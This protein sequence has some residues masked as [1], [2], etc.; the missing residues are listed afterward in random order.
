M[1]HAIAG[2]KAVLVGPLPPPSGG[3]ANQTQQLAR[4]LSTEGIDVEL[5]Q[6]NAPYSPSWVAKYKIIRAFFRFLPYLRSLWRSTKRAQFV[7][8]MAN[9]GWAWHLFAAPAV[10]IAR[11]HRKPVLINYRGG[12]AEAF[13]KRS[14]LFIKPTLKIADAIVVPSGFLEKIFA[15]RGF[16]TVIIANIIDLQRFIASSKAINVSS[17]H[18]IVTRNLEPI[19]D[20]PTSLRA[21][22]IVKQNYPNAR[23]SIA[24]SGPLL[25]ELKNFA[26]ELGIEK[27]VSFVGRL[28]NENIASL[29]HSAD[30]FLN[31]SLTDNMP[32]S[33]L[34]ALACAVP[35]VTSNVGGI[36]YLVENEKSALLVSAG[37]H[38]AMAEAIKR[39]L[40]DPVLV[41]VLT[42]R[43]IEK[44][45]QFSWENI[46]KQW[47]TIYFN[48]LK[49]RE[50]NC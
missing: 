22:A 41:S 1:K 33:V 5:V 21:F 45:R 12:G 37:D 43:G 9:S 29:Y 40:S 36:P 14:F 17:P 47:L 28:D 10:W 4:L 20:I 30:I 46:R 18:I 11:I 19:Y 44:A 27:Q 6:V 31:S 13:F 42:T 15:K 48:L 26:R 34:E 24:G 25:A 8:V 2:H 38:Y 16:K 50:I 7:H 3:M 49:H 35:V 23:L 39:L 32:I